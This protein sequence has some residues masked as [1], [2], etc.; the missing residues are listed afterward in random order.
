MF[1]QIN[2]VLLRTANKTPTTLSCGLVTKNQSSQVIVLG[3]FCSAL[4]HVAYR[5]IPP[6]EANA[7]STTCGKEQVIYIYDA[8]VTKQI[9]FPSSALYFWGVFFR[10]LGLDF[11]NQNLCQSPKLPSHNSITH[12]GYHRS[13]YAVQ[14]VRMYIKN[15]RQISN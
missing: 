9:T 5:N 12:K 4:S 2:Q 15:I 10:I 13:S 6:I 14:N 3:S 7:N 8:R 1:H 11:S